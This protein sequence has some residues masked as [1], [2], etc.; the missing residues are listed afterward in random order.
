[1]DRLETTEV[2][3]T[4]PAIVVPVI[5]LMLLNAADIALTRAGLS[6]GATEAN[7]LAR[8]LLAGGRVELVKFALLCLLALRSLHRRPTFRFAIAC[9][10]A[11]GAYLV[12]VA[13]NLMAVLTLR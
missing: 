8:A 2:T 7:P 4:R 6:L 9:W 5:L 13:S 10:V 1:M 11:T 3:I 12:V